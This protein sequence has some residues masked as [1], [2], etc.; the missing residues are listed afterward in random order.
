M[1]PGLYRQGF[2]AAHEDDWADRLP[3]TTVVLGSLALVAIV[4]GFAGAGMVVW[5]LPLAGK[6]FGYS[7]LT[8]LAVLL[9]MKLI[10]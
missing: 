8:L 4:A 5:T 2:K 1:K 6:L 9:V 7:V 3:A 10:D